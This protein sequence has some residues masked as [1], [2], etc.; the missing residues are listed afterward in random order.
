MWTVER[1]EDWFD[2]RCEL[3]NKYLL[4]G[5]T[6][7]GKFFAERREINQEALF[8]DDPI[9]PTFE[10]ISGQFKEAMEKNK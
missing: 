9:Y 10:R 8:K 1:F 4:P 2:L 7:N 6:Q 5:S 3:W